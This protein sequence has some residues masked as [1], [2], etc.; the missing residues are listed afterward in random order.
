MKHLV[1][2][3]GEVGSAIQKVLE[4]D[5][6]D[7]NGGLPGVEQYDILHICFPY[8]EGFVGYVKAYIETFK[9]DL[10]VVHSSVPVGTCDP[11]GWVH[12]P[13]RGVHPNLEQGVRTFVKYFGGESA[14]V[15]AES[16]K[17]MGVTCIVTERAKTTEALK[18]WDTTAYG[19]MILLEKEVHAWCVRNNV[20][21]LLSYTE[22]TKTYNEGYAALGR[23][24][25]ARPYLKHIP[26]PIGGHCV[27]PN[28]ELLVAGD[29]NLPLVQLL[30]ETNAKL[31]SAQGE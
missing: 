24:E 19:I 7:I 3:L 25:V 1:I 16:F 5:G 31:Q 13:V 26:G 4:C 10:V 20:D 9:P 6:Y 14:E 12:S 15:A 27:I 11:Q 28:A 8:S 22:A 21:F 17:R 30:L 18:L 2:G 23:P 29:E